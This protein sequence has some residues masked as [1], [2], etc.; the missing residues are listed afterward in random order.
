VNSFQQENALLAI[1]PVIGDGKE[2]EIVWKYEKG[3]PEC[4]SLLYDGNRIYMVK[5][6]GMITCLDAKTG[7]LKY[8]ER[9]GAGGPYYASMVCGDGKVYTCSRRG[10]VTVFTAGDTFNVLARN[11]LGERIMATPAIV[12][13]KLYVRTEN[14]IWAFGSD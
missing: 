1:R 2:S 9:L 8:Q 10:V 4:P 13:N 14:H 3:V 7:A 5:N 6:G 11:D 12:D